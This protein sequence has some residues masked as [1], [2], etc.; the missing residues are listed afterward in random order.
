MTQERR[1]GGCA[2]RF[3]PVSF[4]LHA[5]LAAVGMVLFYAPE[6]V[7]AQRGGGLYV[8][9]G[10]GVG[11]NIDSWPTQFRLE[12]EIGYYIDDRP[13]GFFFAFAPSQSFGDSWWVITFA[14]RFGYMFGLYENRDLKFQLGPAG[15]IPGIAIYDNDRFN[16]NTAGVAFHFSFS[17]L[18]RLLL[19]QDHLAIYVRP[20]EFEFAVGDSYLTGGDAV[21]Y[22]FETGV[23]WHF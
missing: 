9:G 17:L 2:T 19:L 10:I 22:V 5:A 7:E 20:T 21:R 13:E 3:T 15:T 1:I 18:L 6:R 12:Q 4:S 16:D 11:V 8:G 23:Q 14:P